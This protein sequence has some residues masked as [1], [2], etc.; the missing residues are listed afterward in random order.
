M[1][2]TGL[3]WLIAS[4]AGGALTGSILVSCMAPTSGQRAP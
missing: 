2:Q 4:F 3:G 1:D